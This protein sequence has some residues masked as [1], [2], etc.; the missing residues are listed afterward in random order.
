MKIVL[1]KI[2]SEFR[3]AAILRT[4]GGSCM[5]QGKNNRLFYKEGKIKLFENIFKLQI[6]WKHLPSF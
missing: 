2:G 6:E 3:Q 1:K 4:E 5:P